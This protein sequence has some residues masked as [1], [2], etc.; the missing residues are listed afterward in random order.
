MKFPFRLAALAYLLP[1]ILS[2]QNPDLN[3]ERD[4]MQKR[5]DYF[6]RPRMF[7]LGF[8]PA[9]A[10][11]QA[12]AERDRMLAAMT[13]SKYAKASAGVQSQPV[14]RSIGPHP[15]T[16]GAYKTAAWTSAL[17]VDPRKS[18]TVYLGGP[19]GGVWKTSNGGGTWAPLTDNQPSLAISSLAID[20]SHPDTVYAGT[21]SSYEYGEGVL[22]STDAGT[23]WTATLNPFAGPFN[24]SSY[25]GGGAHINAMAVSPSNSQIVLAATWRYPNSAAGIYRSAD[26][27][28]TW[29][30]ALPNAPGTAVFFDPTNGN[31]A[32]AALSDYF[33]NAISGVYKSTDAGATWSPVNGSGA[34]SINLT[35]AGTITMAISPSSPSTLYAAVLQVNSF[36]LMGLYQS[37]DAGANWTQ[38]TTLPMLYNKGVTLVVHPKFPNIVFAGEQE[39]WRSLDGG[40][41]WTDVRFGAGSEYIFGDIRSMAFG[42]DGTFYVGCD[43]GVWSTPDA[44]VQSISWTNLNASIVTTQFYPGISIHPTNASIAFGGAQDQGVLRYSGFAPWEAVQDCDG[45][46]TAID[47]MTPANV[48]ATCNN[49]QIF[50]STSAGDRS[51]WNPSRAG[52][53]TTDRAVFIPPMIMDP[54]SPSRLYFGT[55]RL[56]QTLDGANTWTAISG[57]LA[58]GT[59][60]INTMAVASSDANTIYAGTSGGMVQVTRNALAGSGSTW[61]EADTGLPTRSISQIAVDPSNAATAYAAVSGFRYGSDTSG[62]VF[63]T[64]NAGVSWSD[65]SSNLPNIPADDIVVDPDVAGTLYLATD[66]GVFQTVNGGASWQPMGTGLPNVVVNSLKLHRPSR[67]LRAAT[68]GRGMWDLSMSTSPPFGSLDTPAN[69]T[70]GASGSVNVT[71]WAISYAAITNVGIW[72]DP[73]G[74]EPAGANG[75]IFIENAAL[76]PGARPDIATAFPGYPNNN[77]GW[78]AQVLTN[79]LP[80]TTGTAGFGT[81]TYRLHAIATDANGNSADIGAVTIST[82]NTHAVLPFG[83]IDT[84]APGATVSGPAYVNFGWALTP[85]PNMIPVDGSTITVFLD[86]QAVGHPVY[87]QGRADISALFPGYQNTGKAVGYF[88]IDTTKLPNGLHTIAWVVSDNAG[89]SQGIGSRYFTVQN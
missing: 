32:Y 75:L 19:E 18:S 41:T 79:E 16:R 28:A 25:F 39:L 70:T 50:K 15:T 77:A 8:I 37:S 5:S 76:V 56:Y 7:P 67:T 22:K 29:N 89:H 36:T 24:N 10:R 81:G 35:A 30:L 14:W 80:N 47:P 38:L 42:P 17:A 57:D 73:I 49:N 88:M 58:G 26:G 68:L 63:K 13:R 53:D 1:A 60:V 71:G 85:Q 82:D 27:G 69:N 51:T 31:V 11:F 44:T 2:A 23:T 33:G 40:M 74:A 34:K 64:V 3:E 55:Y 66:I 61:V 52:I 78:G 62:H 83:T 87:G 6:L 45:G 65:I 12:L 9:N 59:D 54:S 21:G 43:G 48:Y 86:N 46:W 20:P 4:I 72:C 84:P